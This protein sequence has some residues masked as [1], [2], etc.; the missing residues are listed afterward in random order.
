[1]ALSATRVK[2]LKEP[3]RY[4]DSGGL[5]LYISKAGRK[6]W[7]QRIT[8]DGRRRDIGLGGYPSVSLALAR[9][10][11]A[12]IRTAV[13]AGRDPV[14]ERHA[15]AMPTFREGAQ[16]VHEA[17]KPRWRNARHIA[18]WMQTLERY[19]MPSLSNT[20]LDRIDR[21]DVLRVLTPIWSTRPETARRVRQRM[22][23]IFRWA[24]VHGFIEF[25]PAGEAIDGALPPMPKVKAHFRALPYREVGSALETVAASQASMSAKLCFRFLVL[26]AARS[27]EARGATWNEIDLQGQEW[28]IPSERMKAG[29][30]HRVPLSGQT[31][32]LLGEAS[33]LREDT[34]LVFPSPLK[35]GTPMSDMTLTKILRSVGLAERATVHGFRSSF[36]NWTLEQTDTP[37]VVSEAALAHSLGNSTEQ[38]YARSDLFERRRLLMQLWADYLTG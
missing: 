12:D 8:V 11:A 9:E 37:W 22:R 20:A 7:V 14:A 38:A 2:A 16:A 35:P 4:S 1:M 33:A 18:S 30:E 3:G 34:G 19:A 29:M 32:D 15:S 25:N 31:L 13:A 27:G 36:K 17:N 28:R 26:T 24:M 6:S 21:G 23:T 5:H 10:K